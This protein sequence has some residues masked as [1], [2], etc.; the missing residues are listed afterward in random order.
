MD[1]ASFEEMVELNHFSIMSVPTG[2]NCV[3]GEEQWCIPAEAS[4]AFVTKWKMFS[5]WAP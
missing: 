4:A 5:L 3:P 1:A 2:A